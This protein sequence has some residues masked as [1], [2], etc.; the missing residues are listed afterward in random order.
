M[1]MSR[2][3]VDYL[4]VANEQ[5]YREER[6]GYETYIRF[7]DLSMRCRS[8][9]LCDNGKHGDILEECRVGFLRFFVSMKRDAEKRL[10]L[11]QAELGPGPPPA[12]PAK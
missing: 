11:K 3:H 9:D 2:K 8:C 10:K 12:V 7:A 1:C 4:D 6:V 5:H